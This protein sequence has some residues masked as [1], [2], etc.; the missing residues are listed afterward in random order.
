M[1]D[2]WTDAWKDGRMHRKIILLSHTLTMRGNNA[3]G[4]V[5]FRR[6]V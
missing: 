2:K 6:V 3:A 5:E 4:L 1:T